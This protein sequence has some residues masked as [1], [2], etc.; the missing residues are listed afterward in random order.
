MN[1]KDYYQQ[2]IYLAAISKKNEI[3]G[4]TERW[5]AHQEAILHLGYTVIL[6]Y[7]HQFI[8]QQRKHIVFDQYY[9]LSFSSH[10]I[11]KKNKLQTNTQA[12]TEG[13]FREWNLIPTDLKKPLNKLGEIYYKAKDPTSIFW[14]HEIDI[15]YQAEIKN[16]PNPNFEYCYGYKL[17]NKSDIN[18][19]LAK[20]KITPWV[21]IMLKNNLIK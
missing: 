13:L 21:Y 15:I 8:L 4:K 14:E 19:I 17:I 2:K 16:L 9:D 7:K 18:S 10:Q 20:Y 5:Q 12:I 6:T 1:S 11:Y 3:I